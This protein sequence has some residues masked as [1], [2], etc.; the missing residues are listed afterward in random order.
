M[1]KEEI[2]T[3]IDKLNSDI[4]AVEEYVTELVSQRNKLKYVLAEIK[5]DDI[6][7]GVW[8]DMTDREDE[9]APSIYYFLPLKRYYDRLYG[10]MI[11]KDGND[12]IH[13]TLRYI[14]YDVDDLT[15]VVPTEDVDKWIKAFNEQI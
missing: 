15:K 14:I 13:I 5:A 9:Y 12:N 6:K 11:R 4:D 1:T 3:K 8:Y 7:L 2:K 10:T